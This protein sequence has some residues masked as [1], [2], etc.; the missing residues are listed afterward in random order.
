MTL[1]SSEYNVSVDRGLKVYILGIP[2]A[3][4]SL[5]G[6]KSMPA[7]VT[8][9]GKGRYF[10]TVN[11][12]INEATPA[13]NQTKLMEWSAFIRSNCFVADHTYLAIGD[14]L[15]SNGE[16]LT[17]SSEGIEGKVLRLYARWEAGDDVYYCTLQYVMC[18]EL[19]II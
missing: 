5:F 9:F 17:N 19:E 16:P 7:F 11:F 18:L 8:D 1:E 13:L 10:I 12:I 14:Y 4:S 3:L 15:K 2:S 6:L